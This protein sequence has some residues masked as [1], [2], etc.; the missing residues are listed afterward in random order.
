MSVDLAGRG[1]DQRTSR[2]RGSGGVGPTPSPTV[3][4]GR[5]TFWRQREDNL[6][7]YLFILPWLVGF[8]VFNLGPMLTSL[9]LAFT[10]F[11]LLTSPEWVGLDNFVTMFTNDIRY[12]S[13]VRVTALYALV[14]V[15]FQLALAL[16]LA[17][18]LNRDLR[19]LS[20]YRASYYLPSLLASSVAIAIV[21]RQVFG[22]EGII[23]A[24][25]AVFGVAGPGWMA[26]PDY[27]IYP[28]ICLRIWHFGTPMV[29]F[30]AGLKQIPKEFYEAAAVDGA[31]K[32]PQFFRITLPLLTPI[33]F[34]N[35]V[36]N[37]IYAFRS[38][39]PAFILSNGTGG[40][41]DSMLV[42][43]LYLYKQGFGQFHMGYASAMA[44]VLLSAVA[45]LTGV[46]FLTS[47]HWV[48]Y[49]DE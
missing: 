46:N 14:S 31:G 44:W 15:P 7:G 5:T 2:G 49:G 29:V 4:R 10:D 12:F 28:L 41:L 45:L 47:K 24:I 3:R 42:Y 8:L 39:T 17:M 18:V 43:T 34:F 48:F 9:G 27:A 25:L 1:A 11:D 32:L 19:G 22:Q 36:L 6:Y 20:V 26:H 21:W 30:L 23:N 37:M 13:S 16:V 35:L 33:I 38:F 40:V